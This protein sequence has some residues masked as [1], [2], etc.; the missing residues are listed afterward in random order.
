[1]DFARVLKRLLTAFERQQIR[2]AAIGGFAVGVLGVFRATMDLDF[3]VHRDDLAKLHMVLAGLGYQRV[4]QHENVSHYVH[5]DPSWGALDYI[6]AFRRPS[7]EMLD[8][9]KLVSIFQ[10]TQ[11]IRVAEPEDV[12]GLK[13][14]AIANNPKRQT[15]ELSDIEQLMDVSGARL[16]WNRLQEF[17]E[18][19]DLG[20]LAAELRKRYPGDA[21]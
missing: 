12:I 21:Q 4:F 3:L 20:H 18:L 16:D 17:F 15:K 8:R 13:V 11:Q 7:L 6:H 10:G 1:V 2:Y 19:F 5:P 14:Q 9:A